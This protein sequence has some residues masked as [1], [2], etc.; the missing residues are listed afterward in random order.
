[1]NT[2]VNCV[3]ISDRKSLDF[4]YIIF[5]RMEIRLDCTAEAGEAYA[6]IFGRVCFQ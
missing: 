1:M 5:F 6:E 4:L 3:L 2:P